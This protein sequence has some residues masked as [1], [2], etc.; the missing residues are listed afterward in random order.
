MLR[1][2]LILT[3][4]AQDIQGI[5]AFTIL[6]LAERLRLAAHLSVQSL[7]C[8]SKLTIVLAFILDTHIPLARASTTAGQ[9][10]HAGTLMN[11][12]LTG[13]YH[14]IVYDASTAIY[15]A[16]KYQI[17]ICIYSSLRY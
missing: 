3:Q 10:T 2:S 12:A 6:M 11:R 17:I 8:N 16:C 15:N 13:M 7:E 4:C 14:D 1:F 5:L 9:P